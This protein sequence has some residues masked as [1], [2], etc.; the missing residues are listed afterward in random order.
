[1]D[2]KLR[3][4]VISF[5]IMEEMAVTYLWPLRTKGFE[6]M[7]QS[8]MGSLREL[9]AHG[10]LNLSQLA[11]QVS[12]TNQSMT[13]ISNV[14]VEKGLVRRVY[15]RANRRQIELELT[16]KGKE[17]IDGQDEDVINTICQVLCDLSP[18]DRERLENASEEI[19][20]VLDKTAFGEK[21]AYKKEYE[22]I[23]R[24]RQENHG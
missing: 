15:D 22:Q 8:Q 16:E 24:A 10:R 21:Y 11:M 20:S 19:Y 17:Y 12:V 13:G 1:M 7:N 2:N 5:L 4:T 9:R 6:T 3:Q 23:Y 14:L 18:E